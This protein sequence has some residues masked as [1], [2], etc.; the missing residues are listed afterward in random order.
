MVLENQE[1]FKNYTLNCRA[2]IDLMLEHINKH[3]GL[4]EGTLASM[5]RIN[6]QSGDH[7]RFT[8]APPGQY[9][10]AGARKGEHTDHG[11]ITILFNWL[12]GLQIRM[13]DPDAE[14]VYVRPIPGSCVVN[15]GDAMVKFTAGLLR[16]NI[17]RVVP[18]Q[19]AQAGM[20]RNSLVYFSRPENDVV[21]RRLKGGIIDEQPVS[22]N[23]GEPEL[24]AHEWIMAKV[25]RK[26]PGV[27]TKK[28]FEYKE[29]DER[30]KDRVDLSANPIVAV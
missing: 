2:A 28:G 27:Y 24:T 12:G 17:H 25:S 16:S 9:H 11:S 23:T 6:Q 29:N 21:L 5:H 7:V 14:W 8:Q 15:L 30:L 13:P 4:P 3:L 19:G 26:L 1:T 22:E 18:P 20:T 10:E